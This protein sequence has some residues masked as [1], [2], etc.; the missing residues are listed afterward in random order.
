MGLAAC[1][2]NHGRKVLLAYLAAV[3]PPLIYCMPHLSA[4]VLQHEA[5]FSSDLYCKVVCKK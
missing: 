2:H 1:M 3:E 4:S 5:G